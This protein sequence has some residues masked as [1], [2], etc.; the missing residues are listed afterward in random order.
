MGPDGGWGAIGRG[1]VDREPAYELGG[2]ARGFEE[3]CMARRRVDLVGVAIMEKD[4][5]K[6]RRR[7]RRRLRWR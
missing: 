4:E 7:Q 5:L 2:L 3:L 1:V 6:R